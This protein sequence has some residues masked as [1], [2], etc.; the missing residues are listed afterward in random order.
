METKGRR[1][2]R[3]IR[4]ALEQR[5]GISK[6]GWEKGRRRK[7][8]PVR[9]GKPLR[10]TR[11]RREIPIQLVLHRISNWF[12]INCRSNDFQLIDYWQSPAQPIRKDSLY[13]KGWRPVFVLSSCN[14]LQGLFRLNF[15]DFGIRNLE[16]IFIS[17]FFIKLNTVIYFYFFF[18]SAFCAN[19][20]YCTRRRREGTSKNI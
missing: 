3:K 17:F 7:L 14:S 16:L 12:E 5:Q 13:E 11:R 1:V 15:F 19:N 8:P 2:S 6:A 10:P 18:Y 4:A 20:V 9:K